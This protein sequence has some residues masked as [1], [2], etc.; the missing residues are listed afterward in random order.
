MIIDLQRRLAEVG[1]IRIGQQVPIGNTNKTRPTK[2]TTF[3][4]TSPDPARI[5]A[6]ATLYGGTPEPWQAPA[7]PQHEVVTDA[8][9]L[10]CIVP[11][12]D[13]GFS[14]WYELW[15]GGGCL[16]RCNGRDATYS[17]GTNMIEGGCQC[18]PDRR[19]CQIHTRLS[20]MLRDL[21][22][23]GLWRLDTQGWN[24]A[25]EL[26]GAVDVLQMAAGAGTMLPAQ[27]RLE[28]RMSKQAGQTTKRFAVPVLDVEI[29]PAQLVS[30]VQSPPMPQ[31]AI[32]GTG[33]L[34]PVPDSVTEHPRR[35]IADQVAAEP[36]A[37]KRRGQ[38]PIAATGIAPRTTAQAAANHHDADMAA[39]LRDLEA[40]G[41]L[42]TAPPPEPEPEPDR[43]PGPGQL[44]LADQPTTAEVPLISA[45]QLKK[46]SILLKQ[47]G[48]DDRES[49]H[50]FV[51]AAIGHDVASAKD[52]TFDEAGLVID[53]LASETEPPL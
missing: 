24:A 9:V 53:I 34:T 7:G 13:L 48:F 33:T 10:P 25:L 37:P 8:T 35:S 52:L 14:Q 51:A 27:L 43:A 39:E 38:T 4:L 11:P 40:Q 41:D 49:R 29:T 18:D 26:Q 31:R 42:V 32:G 30:G 44:A 36:A 3:R 19:D 28:Q 23:L 5:T 20:V 1:R 22:G 45:P 50:G 6:A 12:T 46:L 16:R 21:P 15:S 47:A 2:L 17:D